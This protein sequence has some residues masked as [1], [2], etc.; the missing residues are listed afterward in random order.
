MT[1]I[2]GILIAVFVGW[3]LTSTKLREELQ[4]ANT[5]PFKLW[6]LLVRFVAPLA[7]VGVLVSGLQ[8]AA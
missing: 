6:L 3:R 8:P 7:I 1:P 5:W 4:I 2:S